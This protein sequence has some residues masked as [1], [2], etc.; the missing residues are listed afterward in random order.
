LNDELAALGA[1]RDALAAGNAVKAMKA[2]DY[3]DATL[4]GKK[5]RAEARVLRMEALATSGQRKAASRLAERFI[6][7]EPTHPLADRARSFLMRAASTDAAA[8]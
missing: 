2:L 7:A 8:P 6:A 4:R 3:Y 1:A 5:L